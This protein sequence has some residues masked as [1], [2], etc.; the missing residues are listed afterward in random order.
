MDEFFDKVNPWRCESGE[1]YPCPDESKCFKSFR[2]VCND[3]SVCGIDT[4]CEGL[5]DTTG[6][7]KESQESTINY[8]C[9][10]APMMEWIETHLLV[11]KFGNDIDGGDRDLLD[12][13]SLYGQLWLFYDVRY[14][15]NGSISC[16][17]GCLFY[18]EMCDEVTGCRCVGQ[19]I[20]DLIE[21]NIYP[22]EDF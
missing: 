4:M 3:P 17:E 9:R 20:R 11:P 21:G 1:G 19:L 18:S 16:P 10:S 8:F 2:E 5:L 22:E 14:C 13:L 12:D 6:W 15:D 7:C